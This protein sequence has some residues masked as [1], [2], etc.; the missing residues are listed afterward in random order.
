MPFPVDAAAVAVQSVALAVVLLASLTLVVVRLRHPRTA[1]LVVAAALVVAALLVVV[2]SPVDVP[3]LV[4]IG[5]ALVGVALAVV[6]GDPVTRRILDI[7]TRG[8]SRE[9]VRGGILIF[10]DD[11]AA[12]NA[13]ARE[14]LRGGATIGYLERLGVALALLAGYPE[15]IAVVVAVKGIGRFSELAAP[16]ARER[17]IIGTLA[18]MLWAGVVGALVRLAIW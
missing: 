3:P 6:G 15:A 11:G 5:L 4:G 9:G 14:V 2:V 13:P 7:A 17:F 18:S 16:E 10:V 1:P 12:A 8:S